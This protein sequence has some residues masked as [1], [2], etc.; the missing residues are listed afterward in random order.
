MFSNNIMTIECF[1]SGYSLLIYNHCPESLSFIFTI[2]AELLSRVRLFVTPW[3]VTHKAL[4][5]LG[6]LWARILEWVA[7]PSSRRSSQ[8]KVPALQADSSPSE[9][10]GKT[11]QDNFLNFSGK[12]FLNIDA[13]F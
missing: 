11:F 4:P 2:C 3:T 8:P 13:Q 9:P 7:M 10:P 1:K 12:N 5:S 6:I